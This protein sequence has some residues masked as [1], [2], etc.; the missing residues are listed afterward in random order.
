IQNDPALRMKLEAV[1][2][3][4]RR[5]NPDAKLH[6]ESVSPSGT[7][8]LS[9]TGLTA[10]QAKHI[11]LGGLVMGVNAKGVTVAIGDIETGHA[12]KP[13]PPGKGGNNGLNAGQIGASS[14]GSFVT[15]S[16]RDRPVS[17]WHGNGKTG[18]FS[19][20]RTTG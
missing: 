14:L 9:A 1:I 7:L 15:D 3:A 20:T 12:R 19:T 5:I 10:D 17:G 8:S 6:I 18:E 4:A 11:G 13:S 2:K 16:H